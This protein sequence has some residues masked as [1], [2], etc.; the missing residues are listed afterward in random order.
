[1]A[2]YWLCFRSGPG[3]VRLPATQRQRMQLKRKGFGRLKEVLH[4]VL[5][6]PSGHVYNTNVPAIVA[7]AIVVVRCAMCDVCAFK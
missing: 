5:N 3:Y 6:R 2:L 1:M 7:L 4:M